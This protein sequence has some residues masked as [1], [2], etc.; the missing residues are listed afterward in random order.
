MDTDEK[1]EAL[2][3]SIRKAAKILSIDLTEED[4]PRYQDWIA[5][6]DMHRKLWDLVYDKRKVSVRR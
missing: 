1:W 6:A 5:G 4:M 2:L 3:R